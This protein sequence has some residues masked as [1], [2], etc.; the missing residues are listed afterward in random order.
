MDA[1]DV[2]Y[3]AV[4]TTPI[5]LMSVILQSDPEWVMKYAEKRAVLIDPNT[6]LMRDKYTLLRQLGASEGGFFAEDGWHGFKLNKQ[7]RGFWHS[8]IEVCANKGQRSRRSCA[9]SK[10]S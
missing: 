3:G 9:H 6:P 10:Y 8:L 5:A 4:S 1:G 7:A 2:V